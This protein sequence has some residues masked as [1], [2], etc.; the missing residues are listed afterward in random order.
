MKKLIIGL[1]LI[2][3]FSVFAVAQKHKTNPEDLDRDPKAEEF[4]SKNQK[5]IPSNKKTDEDLIKT[6]TNLEAVLNSTLD[7]KKSE[8]GDEVVLKT[9][10]TIKQDGEVVIPKG[11][12]LI[13]RVTEVQRKTKD[14]DVSKIGLVFETLAGKNFSTPINLSLV[15][16]TNS[17]SRAVAPELFETGNSTNSRTSGRASGGGLLGGITSTTGGVINTATST[18]GGVAGT[19]TQ[20]VGGTTQGLVGTI[21][22]IRISQSANSTINGSS[23]LSAENKNLRIKKGVTFQFVVNGSIEK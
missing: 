20:T 10:K 17:Q 21:D 3:I 4:K 11:T 8:V 15:S 19:A 14:N 7:V 5:N 6:G 2:L 9:T 16:I 1:N 12:K 22:G 23:T 18:V 13:G